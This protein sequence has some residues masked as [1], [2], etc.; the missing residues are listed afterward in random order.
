MTRNR[1]RSWWVLVAAVVGC[2][3]LLGCVP[4]APAGRVPASSSVHPSSTSQPTKT[5]TT[6]PRRDIEPVAARFPALADATVDGWA[7]GTL[8]TSATGRVP[9]PSAYWFDAVMNAGADQ[10]ARWAA[11][12]EA[13]PVPEPLSP[14]NELREFVPPGEL[15]GSPELDRAFSSAQWQARVYLSPASG[16]V[17]VLGVDD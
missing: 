9:G 12:Y 17:V 6:G 13:T 3:G 2:A 7:A 14:V 4:S 11:E 5:L 8:G 16:R 1:W 15:L 10:V